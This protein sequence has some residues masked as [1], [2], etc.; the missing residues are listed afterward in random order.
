MA[1]S[2]S[3]GWV[4]RRK[5]GNS[6][7][8]YN[9]NKGSTYSY[10]IG[11]KSNRYT[12]THLPGGKTKITHTTRNG[13]WVKRETKTFGGTT[14]LKKFKSPRVRKIRYRKG[15][16]LSFSGLFSIIFFLLVIAVIFGK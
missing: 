10:S 6:T 12:T 4:R 5:N 13:D 15:K 7:V 1:K 11:G 3:G 14:R 2:G 9:S 16:Q 8:T